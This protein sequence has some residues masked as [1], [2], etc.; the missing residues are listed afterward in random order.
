[1][2]AVHVHAHQHGFVV[3]D[4]AHGQG[5]MGGVRNPVLVDIGTKLAARSDEV[6]GGHP[7]YRRFVG[8]SPADQVGD[9]ADLQTVVPAVADEIAEP[10]HGAVRIQYLADDRG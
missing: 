9:R 2:A 1:H 8:Q 10:R 3:E 7:H 5:K 6:V 4:V